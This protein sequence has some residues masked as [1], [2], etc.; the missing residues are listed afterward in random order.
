MKTY[1]LSE[2]DFCSVYDV[3]EGSVH[4]NNVIGDWCIEGVLLQLNDDGNGLK[5]SDREGRVIASL[6]YGQERDL[7]ALLLHRAKVGGVK[8]LEVEGVL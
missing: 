3:D 5:L 1:I 8:I 4:T 2:G 6:D 7:L